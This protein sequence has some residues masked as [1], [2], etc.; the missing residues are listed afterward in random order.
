[1]KFYVL[2]AAFAGLVLSV[3]GFANAG[4]IELN[5]DTTLSSTNIVGTTSGDNVS[6]VFRFN[7]LTNDLSNLVLNQNNFL[8][9]SFYLNDGRFMTFD[10]LES[11][12]LLFYGSNNFFSFDALGS[13]VGV[14][15]FYIYDNSVMSNIAGVNGIGNGM[16]NNGRNC[17]LC[18][19]TSFSVNNVASGLS[20]SSWTVNHAQV[21]EPSTLAIF[22]LGMIG[23]ASRRFKKQS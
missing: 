8:D 20:A 11:G 15:S 1:M 7:S 17:T 14:Q 9:Y 2:K 21:P 6:L 23:L 4:I 10:L 13:L 18:G 12:S 22:A 5:W 3:S 19:S 16:Y